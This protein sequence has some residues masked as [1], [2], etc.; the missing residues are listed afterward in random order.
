M[1]TMGTSGVYYVYPDISAEAFI[2]VQVWCDMETDG[3]GWTVREIAI[4]LAYDKLN[5]ICLYITN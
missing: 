2:P 3:G 1:Y 4:A 5:N